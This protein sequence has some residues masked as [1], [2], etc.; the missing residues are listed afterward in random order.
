METIIHLPIETEVEG[1]Q[2]GLIPKCPYLKF[3]RGLVAN[4][5]IGPTYDC[6]IYDCGL[7]YA[8]RVGMLLPELLLPLRHKDCRKAERRR[9]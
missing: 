5:I 8:G 2:C 4:H 3:G 6:K 7:K 9:R 1:T